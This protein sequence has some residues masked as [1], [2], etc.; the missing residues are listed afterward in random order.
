MIL[1]AEKNPEHPDRPRL[2]I[3]I[4]PIDRAIHHH[5]AKTGQDIAT[6]RATFGK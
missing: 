3:N 5:E 2:I 1:P 4:I 6:R